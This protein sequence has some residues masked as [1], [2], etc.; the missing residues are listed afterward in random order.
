MKYKNVIRAEFVRR[1]N[2]FIA[3]VLL[4]G[5]EE[6][7]HVKNTGRLKELLVP[8]AEV[9]LETSDNP[10]RKT[11]YDLIAVRKS[12]G[13]LFNIDSQACN[14][15]AGEWLAAQDYDLVRPEFRFGNSRVD[16]YM[17]RAGEKSLLEIK[18]CTL[19]V[20]GI[21]YFPDAPTDRGVKHL[22]EL[23]GAAKEGYHCAVGFVIQMD[24]VK[25]VRPNVETHPAFGDALADAQAAGVDVLLLRCHVEPDELTV[26]A[27]SG[28]ED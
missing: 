23:A 26:V 5:R 24:G 1:Q 15:V 25:E 7:V 21:G 9:W 16:F 14:K 13:I 17:E 8:G 3:E 10:D 28:K 4:D 2:R 27:V 6:T 22:R 18:G 19:E 20:D 11:K 12:N